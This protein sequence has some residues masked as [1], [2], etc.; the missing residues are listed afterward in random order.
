MELVDHS[1]ESTASQHTGLDSRAVNQTLR[2]ETEALRKELETQAQEAERLRVEL[3]LARAEARQAREAAAAAEEAR[4]K[5]EHRPPILQF[6]EGHHLFTE[7]DGSSK[8]ADLAELRCLGVDEALLAEPEGDVE[9]DGRASRQTPSLDEVL[10]A[11]DLAIADAPP[12]LDQMRVPIPNELGFFKKKMRSASMWGEQYQRAPSNERATDDGVAAVAV[13]H[14]GS[15]P[16]SKAGTPPLKGTRTQTGIPPASVVNALLDPDLARSP[17]M[18]ARAVQKRASL[19]VHM[20]DEI[21]RTQ[22]KTTVLD[23]L[24]EGNLSRQY[25]DSLKAEYLERISAYQSYRLA[26]NSGAL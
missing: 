19:A 7:R 17:P 20:S 1:A 12:V 24:S 25:R 13:S 8:D 15:K 5:A 14:N 6:K 2:A 4:A 3:E 10:D 9:D 21:E 11:L 18:N 26:V 23:K 22:L 16:A